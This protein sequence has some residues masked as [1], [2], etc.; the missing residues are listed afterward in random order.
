M[1]A[2]HA[3][4]GIALWHSFAYRCARRASFDRF[5][6][7]AMLRWFLIASSM[8]TSSAIAKPLS[9]LRF[10]Y[11]AMMHSPLGFD[12][13]APVQRARKG[14]LISGGNGGLD[15]AVGSLTLVFGVGAWALV[16]EGRAPVLGGVAFAVFCA[17]ALGAGT[18]LVCRGFLGAVLGLLLVVWVLAGAGALVVVVV[19]WMLA[20]VSVFAVLPEPQPLATSASMSSREMVKRRGLDT[21][22]W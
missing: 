21:G 9:T 7:R 13:P 6:R 22:V 14:S 15:A 3:P 19:G 11:L 20:A 4:Q 8:P 16:C 18:R 1:F 12:S 5:V 17:G 10:S 2:A